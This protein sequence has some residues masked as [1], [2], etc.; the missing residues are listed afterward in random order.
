MANRDSLPDGENAIIVPAMAPSPLLDHRSALVVIASVS[1]LGLILLDLSIWAPIDVASIYVLPLMLAGATRDRR[2]LWIF[3]LVLI[4]ATFVVY[5]LQIPSGAHTLRE[6]I[7]YNRLLDVVVLLFMAGMLQIWRNSVYANEARARLIKAQDE[8]LEAARLSH[9]LVEVQESERRALANQLHDLVGQKL[10]AL[11]INL[12]I[13]KAPSG[14]LDATKDNARLE[15]SM[16]LVQETIESIRDVMA[17]LSPA[18]LG[19]FGLAPTLRWY[20]EGLTK[21]T[22]VAVA[23]KEQGQARRLALHAEEG[24]FRIAQEALTNVA[25]HARAREVTLTTTFTPR[26]ICLRIADDGSGFDPAAPREPTRDNGWGLSIMRQRAATIG[27]QF[28]L[29]SAPGSGTRVSVTLRSDAS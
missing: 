10:T 15:D 12:Q 16:R 5:A 22:G 20:A 26:E 2:V 18:V 25:K 24:L 6:P 9:R 4:I 21:R 23:M 27:A 13:M 14:S 17:E 7:F 29:E 1:A 8:K 3:T 11:S 19:D 28:E